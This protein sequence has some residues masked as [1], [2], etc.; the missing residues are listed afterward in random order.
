MPKRAKCKGKTKSGKPCRN[1]PSPGKEYCWRHE[2]KVDEEKT[3]GLI[4]ELEAFLKQAISRLKGMYTENEVKAAS[5]LMI[6]LL[7]GIKKLFPASHLKML[8]AAKGLLSSDYLVPDTWKDILYL[9]SDAAHSRKDAI[10][11]RLRGEY[12][13]D[14]YGLDKDVVDMLKPFFI[15]MYRNYWRVEMSGVENI[16]REGPA[17]LVAN[18]SGILPWDGAMLNMG[19]QLEHPHPRWVRA[20]YLSW[21][22]TIPIVAP[23]L[24][25]TGQLLACPE[26][27]ERLLSEDELVAVFPEGVKGA[28]KLF[29]DR[30]HLARFGRGGFVK[31]AIRTNAPILP[32][33]I[34]GAEEI[35]PNI[36]KSKVLAK[37]LDWP[38]FPISP[39]WPWLGPIGFIPLPS[40][41]MIHISPPIPTDEYEPEE[42]ENYVLVS[43]LTKQVRDTVQKEIL[44]LL[45]KR[46]SA[47]AL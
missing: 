24:T 27:G 35:Y 19:V 37:M 6:E 21:L 23:F 17:L 3:T 43:K 9:S 46:G 20:L 32:V 11:K 42:A 28:G 39:T 34:I 2:P 41:W 10:I 1:R 26:N 31:I 8:S 30:Y 12:E 16:P 33:S 29:A 13:V 47:F 40:K 18:H 4:T 25:R 14:K 38:L 15:F 45:A 44:K 5:G 22:P 7:K 36:R